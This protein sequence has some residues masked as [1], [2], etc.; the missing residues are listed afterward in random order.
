MTLHRIALIVYLLAAGLA[1][2][3]N[4]EKKP[5]TPLSDGFRE[6]IADKSL[7]G[8]ASEDELRRIEDSV[9][10]AP[11]ASGF[12][13]LASEIF[14]VPVFVVIAAGLVLTIIGIPLVAVL[15]PVAFFAAFV[16]MV[17]GFTAIACRI[18]EWVEDRLGWRG[19]SA[20]L[21]SA[22]GLTL[23]VAPTV[24]SRMISVAPEP[25]RITAFGLLIAGVLIEFIIWTIGLGATLMTGFGRWSTAPPPVP[26]MPQPGIVQMAG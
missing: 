19:K 21:A 22:I 26:P 18:G 17:L 16:T 14:M 15:L 11:L 7:S 2:G 24:L 4:A 8:S 23:I 20:F 1:F 10:E 9:N 6:F 25:L 12:V 5:E 13:G 3:A